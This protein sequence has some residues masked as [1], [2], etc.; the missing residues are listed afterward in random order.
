MNAPPAE[1]LAVRYRLN[2]AT[3][4]S[5]L[6]SSLPLGV[7]KIM[8][9][10]ITLSRRQFAAALSRLNRTAPRRSPKAILQNARLSLSD[11]LELGATDMERC[12]TERVEPYEIAGNVDGFD[13][14]ANVAELQKA[15]AASKASDVVVGF[16]GSALTV[17]GLQ[18]SEPDNVDEF[19]RLNHGFD[20]NYRTLGGAIVPAAEFARLLALA[21]FCT[22]RD[23]SRYALGAVRLECSAGELGGVRLIATDG[24]RLTVAESTSS[25]ELVE[26]VF[27]LWPTAAAELAERQL[28][29]AANVAT[30]AVELLQAHRPPRFAP[31]TEPGAEPQPLPP[32]MSADMVRF[33]TFDA[34]GNALSIVT[35][36]TIEGRYPNWR[37]VLPTLQPTHRGT[38]NV[39]ALANV[40]K[41]CAAIAEPDYRGG[42]FAFRERLALVK[43]KTTNGRRVRDAL[44]LMP[45]TYPADCCRITLDVK[46][47]GELA[48][49]AAAAG[50][51]SAELYNN[52]ASSVL[53]V[54]LGNVGVHI[55]MPMGRDNPAAVVAAKRKQRAERIDAENAAKAA[56]AAELAALTE[57]ERTAAA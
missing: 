49:A 13:M 9:T 6:Y 26:P 48:K 21:T 52:D 12:H 55:I 40:A 3:L 37:Q 4:P 51:D 57:A 16:T 17:D 24:R 29:K 42:V 38:V 5:S 47:L 30:V 20:E 43:Y 32:D 14:L 18:L 11:R 39:D 56:A 36:R 35:T 22:D 44:R 34:A 10:T 23:S 46:F 1:R 31:P 33:A 2:S 45:A 41:R 27:A 19:P 53:M 54:E 50:F 28:A 25:P 15:V 7:L 8:S